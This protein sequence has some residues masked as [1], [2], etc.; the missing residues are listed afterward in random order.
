MFTFQMNVFIVKYIYYTLWSTVMLK[1]HSMLFVL[2]VSFDR[3]KIV[4]LTVHS[5]PYNF[6]VLKIM[7]L[8]KP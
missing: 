6:I 4:T 1:T 7:Q 3:S 5:Y 8:F 2:T